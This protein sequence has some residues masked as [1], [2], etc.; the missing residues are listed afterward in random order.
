[1][2][3]ANWSRFIKAYYHTGDATSFKGA[4]HIAATNQFVKL[5]LPKWAYPLKR[6]WR[7]VGKAFDDLQ[8]SKDI[9]F[10]VIAN[11]GVELFP[12]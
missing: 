3:R 11:N 7:L 4:L 12:W 9:S 6:S 1:M 8:V 10:F 2:V 5:L